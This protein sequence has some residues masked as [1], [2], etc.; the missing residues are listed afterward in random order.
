[1]LEIQLQYAS[2]AEQQFLKCASVAGQSFS[3]WAVVTMLGGD[4]STAED[5]C[6]AL[7]NRQQFLRYAGARELPNKLSTAEYQFRHALYRKILYGRLTPSQRATFHHRL[8][9]GLEGL[10]PA[11]APELASEI[12]SHF[13]EAHEHERAIPYLVLMASNAARRYA[14]RETIAILEHAHDLLSRMASGRRAQLELQILE[15]IGNAHYALGE[16]AQSAIAYETIAT[17]AAESGVLEEQA[18]AL[19]RAGHPAESIPF[20]LR[21]IE[22]DPDLVAA[23]TTLSRIYS[24]VGET[25]P[26][27][28]FAKRAYDRRHLVDDREQLSI[29]YQFYFEVTG[30]QTRATETLDSWK[31]RYPA[32]FQPVNSLALIHNFLGR[33]ESAIEAG[34]E[35]VKR[36]PSHGYPYSNLAHAYRGAGRF[37]EAR[38]TAER[39]VTLEIETLP[40]RRLLYQLA[41]VAGDEQA[42]ARHVE[43]AKD[44]PR[45]F[46]MVGARAQAAA[47]A[48]RVEEARAL[49][50]AAARMAERRNLPDV[51]T[52]HLAWATSMELAFGNMDRA[53]ELARRV[54]ERNPGYDSELRAALIL[55]LHGAPRE[56]GSVADKL[57]RANPEH[58]MINSVLVPIVRAGIELGSHRPVAA[59]EHLA[60]VAPYELGFIAA[61][62]PVHLRAHAYLA[63][64]NG[65]E[66]ADA[67][68]RVLDRRGTDP[69]SPFHAVAPLGAARAFAIAGDTPASVHMYER[70]LTSWRGAD[71]DVPVLR[72]ARDESPSPYRASEVI[73]GLLPSLRISN[74]PTSSKIWRTPTVAPSTFNTEPAAVAML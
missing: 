6:D 74:S 36:N 12:A 16:M 48:G 65:R 70:F 60:V 13:E 19:I 11:A 66:A 28:D 1:M 64:G 34:T 51:G 10:R 62:I 73:V 20:F 38:Q 22:I 24:N 45:E 57:A 17:R 55:A 32:E 41:I 42:A 71:A 37:E 43:W 21:A 39:A 47:W 23:Y 2:D 30:D 26:A 53:V 40:T 50:D 4:A 56:A 18:D 35:A 52:S 33:F 8:A 15:R 63:L 9:A 29:A 14:H 49:Y 69:F 54:L 67:F 58:T 59:L 31:E 3:I 5:I 27:R 72:E 7:A 68:Q 61:L 25:E 44:K 46:D